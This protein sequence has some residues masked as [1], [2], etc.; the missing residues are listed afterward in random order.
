MEHS[1]RIAGL[2]RHRRGVMLPIADRS[3]LRRRVVR[4]VGP[5]LA[6]VA[7][8]EGNGPHVVRAHETEREEALRP[9]AAENDALVER[10]E[11]LDV[12]REEVLDGKELAGEMGAGADG[13]EGGGMDAMV[14]G[15]RE[16]KR[17][18]EETVSLVWV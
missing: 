4:A 12:L 3:A 7:I 1:H 14:V 18:R 8:G 5:Q 16:I 9:A 17:D 2:R 13:E 15:G 11:P 10:E 6:V